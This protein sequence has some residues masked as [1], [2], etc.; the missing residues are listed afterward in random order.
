MATIWAITY[1]VLIVAYRGAW[2]LVLFLFIKR[3]IDG[4]HAINIFAQIRC[5]TVFH[6]K[7]ITQLGLALVSLLEMTWGVMLFVLPE[8]WNPLAL[9]VY[10]GLETLVLT[11]YCLTIVRLSLLYIELL[12]ETEK[13]I[14]A[15]VQKTYFENEPQPAVPVPDTHI[16]GPS[17]SSARMDA[18]LAQG[19]TI[20][21]DKDGHECEPH[22]SS[23]SHVS[24]SHTPVPSNAKPRVTSSYRWV[25]YRLIGLAC[26]GMI[27]MSMITVLQFVPVK[28]FP[29][30]VVLDCF[31]Q[32]FIF[33]LSMTLPF[34][35]DT[36]TIQKSPTQKRARERAHDLA[37]DRPKKIAPPLP[38]HQSIRDDTAPVY[39]I[40]RVQAVGRLV[41]R[42]PHQGLHQGPLIECD[43]DETTS[44]HAEVIVQ[45]V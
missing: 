37:Q 43:M 39:P 42:N 8:E 40:H 32:A 12:N 10:A 38:H 34:R 4:I 18:R 36:S 16:I 6:M 20:T 1:V 22:R 3:I 44:S 23:I 29:Y 9:Q 14:E 13:T 15:G 2:W 33:F 21:D 19:R 41:S 7:R 11:V 24:N 26:F 45:E 25:F 28:D 27:G 35:G 30:Q 5:F 17:E 31:R